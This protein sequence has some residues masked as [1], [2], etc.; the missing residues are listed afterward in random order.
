[1]A[2]ERRPDGAS[3]PNPGTASR[4]SCGCAALTTRYEISTLLVV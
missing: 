1:M 2:A 3:M 4:C